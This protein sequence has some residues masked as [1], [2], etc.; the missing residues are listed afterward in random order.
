MVNE[1]DFIKGYAKIVAQ[2]WDDPTYLDELMKQP[3]QKLAEVGITTREGARVNI[4]RL[5]STGE[6][7]MDDQLALWEKG[8]E[9]GMYQLLVPFKPA[10]FDPSNYPLT[11]AQLEAVSGGLAAEQTGDYCCCCCPCC[12]CT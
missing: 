7:R 1:V 12:C 5:E 2:T 8:E 10:N 6:G 11:D 9:T 4:I 3:E